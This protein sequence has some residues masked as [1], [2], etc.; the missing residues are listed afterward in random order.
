MMSAYERE[1]LVEALKSTRGNVSQASR[2]LGTTARIF[3][4]RLRKLKIRPTQY[5]A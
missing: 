3:S 5:R 2:M 1:V 4:Y